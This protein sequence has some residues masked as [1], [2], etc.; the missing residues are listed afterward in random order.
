MADRKYLDVEGCPL[1]IDVRHNPT[2]RQR[3]IGFLYTGLDVWHGQLHFESG[4][5]WSLMLETENSLGGE[6]DREF[7]S[8]CI[9]WYPRLFDTPQEALLTAERFEREWDGWEPDWVGAT[10]PEQDES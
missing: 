6:G 1:G 3:G 2:F 9:Y 4:G 7:F 8:R 10:V 5:R